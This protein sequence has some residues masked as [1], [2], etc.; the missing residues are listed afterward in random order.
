MSD[1]TFLSHAP[2]RFRQVVKPPDVVVHRLEANGDIPNNPRL[3]LI[4]LRQALSLPSADP[5]ATIEAIFEHNDWPPAWRDSV[6]TFHHY[7]STSHEVLGIYSGEATVRFGG[8]PGVDVTI[9]A[10]DVVIIP[11]GV[12]HKRLSSSPDFAVVGAYPQGLTWDMNYGKP[13][14]HPRVDGNIAAVPDPG[15]DP[16]FGDA[17]PL[18]TLWRS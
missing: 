14:E 3:P 15:R 2:E 7:H 17:G 13:E 12:S 16:V 18:V 9:H 11:A 4:V 8:D 6:Y 10:G 1:D 5:A